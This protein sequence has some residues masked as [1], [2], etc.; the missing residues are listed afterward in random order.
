MSSKPSNEAGHFGNERFQVRMFETSGK[1]TTQN[2]LPHSPL[3]DSLTP[4]RLLA[5][6]SASP[7]VLHSSLLPM[8]PL[9]SDPMEQPLM[10]EFPSPLLSQDCVSFSLDSPECSLDTWHLCMIM[11]TNT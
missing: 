5:Y 10:K 9:S 8:S 3:S 11:E 7:S 2:F 6:S 1:R 4:D